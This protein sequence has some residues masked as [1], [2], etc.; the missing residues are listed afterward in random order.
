MSRHASVKNCGGAQAQPDASDPSPKFTPGPWFADPQCSK[1]AV[2]I[3]DADRDPIPCPGSG[4]SMSFTDTVCELSWQ[5][6]EH[7]ANAFLIASA[8]D[9][10]RALAQLRKEVSEAGFDDATDYNW[11]KA[12]AD[13]DAALRKAEGGE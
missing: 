12:I 3:D 4:G 5:G 2:I 6:G 1:T 7:L 11:P 9:L 10:Y 8:P 13:A